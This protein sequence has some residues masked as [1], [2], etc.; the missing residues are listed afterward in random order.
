M[1]RQKTMSVVLL[2]V[3]T[4]RSIFY[5]SDCGALQTHKIKEPMAGK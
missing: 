5:P 4:L 2:R 3:L 1:K